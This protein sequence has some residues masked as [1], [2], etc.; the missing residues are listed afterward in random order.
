MGVCFA[1]NKRASTGRVHATLCAKSCREQVQQNTPLFDDL[2]G[3]AK[4]RERDHDAECKGGLT[5]IVP[6]SPE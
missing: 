4:Q 2:V 5:A 1:L 3:A 6:S